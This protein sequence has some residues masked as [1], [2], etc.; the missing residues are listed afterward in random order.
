MP[1]RP[2][3]GRE[4][5]PH[6]LLEAFHHQGQLTHAE[7]ALDEQLHLFDVE[8][9][10]E[11]VERAAL[12][13]FD[14]VLHRALGGHHQE[15]NV[16]TFVAGVRQQVEAGHIRQADIDDRQ[17]ET[18]VPQRG[19]GREPFGEGA[20]VVAASLERTLQHEADGLFV[21]RD[22]DARFAHDPAGS[23]SQAGSITR[24]SVRP[25]ALSK[26]IEPPWSEVIR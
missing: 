26:R 24:N 1:T 15:G 23:L 18:A 19:E 3:P 10:G 7:R 20:Y 12:H 9:L 25:G 14:R 13:R 5:G 8:R 16:E 21:F 2:T 11:I 17:V 4:L 6:L 22:E